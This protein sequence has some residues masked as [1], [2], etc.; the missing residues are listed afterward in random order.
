MLLNKKSLILVIVLLLMISLTTMTFGA[1]QTDI[2]VGT[3]F[4]IPY[5]ETAGGW[6]RVQYK[7]LQV[8]KNEFGWEISIAENVPYLPFSVRAGG[9]DI[10]INIG[11]KDILKGF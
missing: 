1:K 10:L 7:G 8:L 2:K 9:T 11:V 5:P 4:A 6:D 3:M